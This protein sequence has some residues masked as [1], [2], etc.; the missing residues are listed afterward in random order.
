MSFI[1][2][3]NKNNDDRVIF[4]S[5]FVV[6]ATLTVPTFFASFT[7]LSARRIRNRCNRPSVRHPAGSSAPSRTPQ[8]RRLIAGTSAL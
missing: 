7:A 3:L 8:L 5:A 6:A 2:R 1:A 4:Q